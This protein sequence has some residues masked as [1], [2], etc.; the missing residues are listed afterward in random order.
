MTKT[1]ALISLLIVSFTVPAGVIVV[2]PYKI[3]TQN[4]STGSGCPGG[5]CGRADYLP[6]N[7]DW[8]FKPDN[9]F[10]SHSFTD[11]NNSNTK[12]QYVGAFGDMNCDQTTVS[13]P[14]PPTSPMYRVT[15]YFTNKS[16]IP[17]DTNKYPIVLTNML[18]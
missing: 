4:C 5:F 18:Q 10:T 2:K 15:V 8:G 7:G 9:G 17:T 6:T 11:T 12:I 1:L 16:E 13:I 14:Q 3:T